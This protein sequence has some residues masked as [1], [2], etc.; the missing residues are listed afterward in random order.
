MKC[1][2]PIETGIKNKEGKCYRS[3]VVPCGKC[4]N[5]KL[6]VKRQW[7]LRMVNEARYYDNNSFVTFTYSEDNIPENRSLRKDAFRLFIKAF[8]EKLRRDG[9]EELR[10][11]AVGEYGELKDRPH[12]HMIMFGYDFKDVRY[13]VDK[14]VYRV[15]DYLQDSWKK[16]FVTSGSATFESMQYCAGYTLKKV[17]DSKKDLVYRDKGIEP[18]F[19]IM[20]RRP[21]IGKK[22]YDEFIKPKSL[23]SKDIREYMIKDGMKLGL[24]RYYKDKIKKDCIKFSEKL[25]VERYD[26]NRKYIEE[27]DK[28]DLEKA[29]KEGISVE[30]IYKDRRFSNKDILEKRKRESKALKVVKL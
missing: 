25:E 5:C 18:E 7:A 27:K 26:K 30:K 15:V 14:N 22:F 8:R 24:P 16:G 1:L 21:G 6:E 28:L 19:A 20:S 11:F 3:L 13:P 17:G 2:Y 23:D 9:K 4:D 10:Y 12:Y 29:E